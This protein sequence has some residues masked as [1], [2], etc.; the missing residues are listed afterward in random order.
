MKKLTLQEIA[1]T[2]GGTLTQPQYANKTIT[3]IT[4][5]SRRAADNTLFIPLKGERADGHDFILQTFQS[6]AVCSLSEKEIDTE[7][8]VI[9]VESCYQAIK[10]I[11]EYYRSLFN[12]PVIGITG[13]VGKTSTKEMIASVLSQSYN[14]HKTQGNF[15]NELGVPLTIFGLEEEHQVAVVEMGI[16]DFGEMTRL[17]KIVKPTISV[18]TN[19]GDCHLSTITAVNGSSPVF[20]GINKG[21]NTYYSE[22]INNMGIKGISCTLCTPTNRLEVTIPAI[23]TYMVANALVAVAIG[24]Y[25]GMEPAQIK[26]GVES[27]KTVGSRD[28]VIETEYI[29]VID[30]CYNANPVSVKGGIDTLTNFSGRTVC[31]LGD[32]KELGA[33]SRQLHCDTGKYAKDK[34][35]DVLVAVGNDAVDIAEGAKGGNTAVYYFENVAEAIDSL[36]NI[37]KKNDTV[38]VKASRAMR[39]EQVVNALKELKV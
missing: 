27:Y 34:G 28:G 17:S 19:I 35:V 32:M 6:G 5:D 18:I 9:M 23:G 10:D 30:D 21:N 16:S 4:T 24:E 31:V 2:C 22:N 20:Y 33:N 26:K 38:L 13:S 3:A 29:T 14:V 39:L 37:I 12:I 11:A 1:N 25:L 8:P 7:N 15:N 36:K